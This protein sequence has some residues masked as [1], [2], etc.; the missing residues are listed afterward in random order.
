M[1]DVDIETVEKIIDQLG[2]LP[3]APEILAKALKLT[4]DIE[5]KIDDI[6]K[7][8]SAD[9]T[10]T[11]KVIRLSNSPY[12]GRV[13]QISSL[14]EAIKVLGFNQIKSIVIT[15]STSRMFQSGSHTKIA[16]VLWEHS[17]A[18][19]LGARLVIQKYGGLDREEGYLCGLVHDI[20]KLVL[21]KTTPHVY[22]EIIAEVKKTNM[23]F[24]KVEGKVLGFN[25]VHVG[26]VLLSKWLFPTH[27]I[28]QISMHHSTKPNQKEPS[29]SL[30]RVIAIADSIAKYIGASFFE[31]YQAESVFFV[32]KRRVSEED[33]ISLRTDTEANFNYEMSCFYD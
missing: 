10:I 3:A 23:S 2:D 33:L 11:A 7:Y 12:Y 20:G 13:Q 17:L 6:S 25:H 21:L 28:S 8:I 29:I 32:G 31:P 9:Q 19:A 18:S 24:L 14:F 1:Q 27:L 5:S 15:A 22:E 16:R 4:S 26:Q 30:G